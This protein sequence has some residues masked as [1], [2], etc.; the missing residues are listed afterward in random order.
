VL[1]DVE[2]VVRRC[3]ALARGEAIDDVEGQPLRLSPQSVCVHGDT[4]GAADIA[5]RVR[6]ALMDAGA[7][8]SP[9]T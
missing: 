5:L 2:Q 3:V 9:F 6:K 1:H 7:M 8:L 4:P